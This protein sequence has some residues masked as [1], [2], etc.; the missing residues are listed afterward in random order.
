MQEPNKH[1]IIFAK[2]SALRDAREIMQIRLNES[3]SPPSL[4]QCT[5]LTL[6]AVALGSIVVFMFKA[7]ETFFFGILMAFGIYGLWSSLL[8]KRYAEDIKKIDDKIS[9]IRSEINDKT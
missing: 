5:A 2:I 6:F 8:G 9:K 7:I 4:L 3:N 1:E